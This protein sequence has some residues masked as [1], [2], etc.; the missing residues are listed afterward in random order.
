MLNDVVALDDARDFTEML[1]MV[2]R[3]KR[4]EI[5]PGGSQSRVYL[6]NRATH[7]LIH[8]LAPRG[9]LPLLVRLSPWAS[10][11]RTMA[12][13]VS[14]MESTLRFATPIM[15][16]DVRTSSSVLEVTLAFSGI[17]T[18]SSEVAMACLEGRD[19][20]K[21]LCRRIKA[22]LEAALA[23]LHVDDMGRIVDYRKHIRDT[24]ANVIEAHLNLVGRLREV[25]YVFP[26]EIL[27][28][29]E[30]MR[31]A[32][33]EHHTAREIELIEEERRNRELKFE[34]LAAREKAELEREEQVANKKLEIDIEQMDF[35]RYGL[36]DPN[37]KMLL[38]NQELRSQ[39]LHAVYA[40]QIEQ[41]RARHNGLN[42]LFRTH[43]DMV[44]D[45]CVRNIDSCMT[46]EEF[47][48][49]MA[50]MQ[51]YTMQYV[52]PDSIHGMFKEF[53]ERTK[54]ENHEKMGSHASF[55]GGSGVGLVAGQRSEGLGTA[56][57]PE[58]GE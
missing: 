53:V 51:K 35:D 11:A 56:A 37:M 9:G 36:S 10:A 31:G 48:K 19:P 24:A 42:E 3:L 28:A 34:L 50:V 4:S 8:A 17:D 25:E 12:V 44:R 29:I 40:A 45:Y 43:M 41:I 14:H 26:K 15:I 38:S 30:E 58:A 21:V 27:D 1:G 16:G 39:L 5:G 46:P 6:L 52:D 2:Q 23:D 47:D 54:R 57:L 7:A 18:D 55:N 13:R 20:V 32:R 22:S 33:I 49:V